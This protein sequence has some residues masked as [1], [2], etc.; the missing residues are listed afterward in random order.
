VD[1]D[2]IPGLEHQGFRLASIDLIT[3]GCTSGDAY[4]LLPDGRHIDVAWRSE[5]AASAASWSRPTGPGGLGV[6]SVEIT[7]PVADEG[8]LEPVLEAAARLVEPIIAVGV[9]EHPRP[10]RP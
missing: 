1:F 8:D 3:S 4:L 9:E 6:I 10:A 7:R 5:M 2:P